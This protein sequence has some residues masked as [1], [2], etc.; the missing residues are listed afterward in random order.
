MDDK[1]EAKI[2]LHAVHVAFWVKP[3]NYQGK[4]DGAIEAPAY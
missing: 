3:V 1:M 2:E 4:W